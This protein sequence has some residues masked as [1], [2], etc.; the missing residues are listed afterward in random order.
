MNAYD[1]QAI[2]FPRSPR[3]L[4]MRIETAMWRERSVQKNLHAQQN[5]DLAILAWVLLAVYPL[6]TCTRVAILRWQGSVSCVS[7]ALWGYCTILLRE[8]ARGLI[9]DE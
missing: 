4:T 1:A 2:H 5:V 8:A 6:L 9:L 7:W 3:S